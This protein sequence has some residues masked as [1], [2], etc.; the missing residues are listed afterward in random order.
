MILKIERLSAQVLF[1]GSGAA[2][3]EGVKSCLPFF[4]DVSLSYEKIETLLAVAVFWFHWRT[5]TNRLS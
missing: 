4:K 5:K 2:F 3:D 1:L